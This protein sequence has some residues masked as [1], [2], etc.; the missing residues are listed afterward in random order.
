MQK[1][2]ATLPGSIHAGMIR[3]ALLL[4]VASVHSYS[5]PG[6][7]Y[8][9]STTTAAVRVPS[10]PFASAIPPAWDELDGGS[11]V[12]RPSKGVT[13]RALVH[14][15]GGVFV[16]PSPQNA[17]RYVLENL[18]ARGYLV[19][20]TPFAVDFDYRR[21]AAEIN[22]KFGRAKSALVNEYGELPQLAMGHSLG[23]LM[24]VLLSC[25]YSEYADACAAAALIS[26]NNKPASDAIPAFEQVFVPALAPLEPLTRLPA[27][28]EARDAAKQF[29]DFGFG[30]ARQGLDANPLGGILDQFGPPGAQ[31]AVTEAAEAALRDA[32]ALAGLADQI[33]DVLSQ[34][35]RGSSEFTPTPTEMASL[36]ASSYSVR[37]TPHLPSSP[38]PLLNLSSSPLPSAPE[39]TCTFGPA[40][41]DGAARRA[42]LGRQPRRVAG[43]EGRAAPRR[44]LPTGQAAGHA[45]HAS[46][47]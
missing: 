22:E 47:S 9:P 43:A 32:E 36:V 3:T 42:V 5:I 11:L 29:R 39:L 25:T 30:L 24:Q 33:P 21:P 12:L 20:V 40:A 38:L 4:L 18:S 41:G 27:L 2:H 37:P 45:P 6:V 34:I 8:S 23:A 10:P 26:Y 35:A 16:S 31:A 1:R 7:S 28:D 17:Y 44:Q 13:P 15:L 19:V 46:S 14:F